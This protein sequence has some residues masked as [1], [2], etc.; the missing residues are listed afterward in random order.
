MNEHIP[1][2]ILLSPL[3]GS[4]FCVFSPFFS[5]RLTR[6]LAW[7]S[8]AAGLIFTL[9]SFGP[10]LST[11]DWRYALGG[12]P[13][14]WGIELVLTPFT[15]FF[16][17]LL[18][19]L[20]LVVLV[21]FRS[22]RLPG[23]S[24]IWKEN[25]AHSF[26][27]LMT[28]A[29]LALL[30]TRDAVNLFL[31]LEVFLLAGAG[32]MASLGEKAWLAAFNFFFWGSVG[33]TLYLAGIVFLYSATATPNLDDIL[34]QLFI[35]KNF[36][37]ALT[38]GF[39]LGFGFIFL[40]VFPAP[41]FFQ[42]TLNRIPSFLLAFFSSVI[43][44][45]AAVLLFGFYFF[46]L[47]VPGLTAPT[48]LTVLA[49]LVS[50]A[51]LTGFFFASRQKD[52]LVTLGFLGAAQMGFL[53]LGFY[54]GNKS[55]LTGSLLEVLSQ[56]LTVAGLFF[57]GQN[58]RE[59]AGIQ[60]LSRLTGLARQRPLMG[61]ALVIFAS[62]IVGVPPT[63]GFFGKW[64]LAQGA[65]EKH[66]WLALATLAAV[67]VFNFLFF[68]RLTRLLYEHHSDYPALPPTRM[69]S[70]LPVLLLAAAILLLGVF[71]E[72]LIHKFIEPAL[73]KAFQNLPVPN[74]PFL[75]KEVE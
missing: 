33:A 74:V 67:T 71:H 20:S 34:A 75:G 65:M 58:L 60:S 52:Y 68:A 49:Y 37:M 31:F 53:F 29:G 45:L 11:G 57:I 73:P 17:C 63:G 12:W 69:E 23:S 48:W 10:L 50:L 72:G 35:A 21:Y 38:A 3:A 64:F 4:L 5:G 28:A 1:I 2:L 9:E 39:F 51:F 30:F 44:R 6:F 43:P 13:P 62:S 70:R 7:F 8:L 36:S 19:V 15:A 59:D 16:A 46:V 27:L 54:L 61:L 24:G 26:H 25:L 22:L 14:P 32:L 47:D 18:L 41:F 56:V 66:D 42:K 55:A 40:L